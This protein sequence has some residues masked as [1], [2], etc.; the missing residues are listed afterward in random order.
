MSSIECYFFITHV[1]IL[2][3]GSYANIFYRNFEYLI[4]AVYMYSD[5]AVQTHIR[6]LD[7]RFS[8]T[9]IDLNRID[10]K[11]DDSEIIMLTL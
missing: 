4:S 2:R 8:H 3:N 6:P 7:R 1:R 11:V 9:H 5:N 10:P